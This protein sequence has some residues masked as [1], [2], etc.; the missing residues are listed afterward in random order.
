MKV[1][2]VPF[3]H[4]SHEFNQMLKS[5]I[6]SRPF[7]P[8]SAGFYTFSGTPEWEEI[9]RC[10]FCQDQKQLYYATVI[11]YLSNFVFPPQCCH[12][13]L[14]PLLRVPKT[15]LLILCQNLYPLVITPVYSFCLNHLDLEKM[16]VLGRAN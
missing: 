8:S 10:L 14:I 15:F 9:S 2:T 6:S 4:T 5:D 1:R 3:L 11:T 12:W 13:K 7:R 16:L